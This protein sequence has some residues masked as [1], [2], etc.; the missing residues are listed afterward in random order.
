MESGER[1][2]SR[3]I[4]LVHLAPDITQTILEG[5]QPAD[6]STRV[7]IAAS[8]FPLEWNEQRRQFGFTTL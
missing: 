2:V 8:D 7:L 5:R 6:L 3:I 1:Y 4:R